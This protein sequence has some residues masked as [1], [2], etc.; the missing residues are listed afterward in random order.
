MEGNIQVATAGG[1]GM[2][3]ACSCEHTGKTLTAG[4]EL[5]PK[6]RGGDVPSSWGS[7]KRKNKGDRSKGCSQKG[8]ISWIVP[9]MSLRESK[10]GSS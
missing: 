9:E 7:Q 8:S 10:A 6:P 1:K 3:H 4:Q 2:S 5:Q